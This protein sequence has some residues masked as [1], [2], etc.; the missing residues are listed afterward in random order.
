MKM[1]CIKQIACQKTFH[2]ISIGYILYYDSKP[3]NRQGGCG[4]T[5][6]KD[7]VEEG[8][9]YPVVFLSRTEEVGLNM[10]DFL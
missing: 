8:W 3:C 7:K 10:K 9:G 5:L 1:R 6:A 4:E 2:A